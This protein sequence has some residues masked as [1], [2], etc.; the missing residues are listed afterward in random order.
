MCSNHFCNFPGYPEAFQVSQTFQAIRKLS[1][2]SGKYP[3]YPENIQPI[4]KTSSLS[5]KFPAYPETFQIIRKISSLSGKF[6]DNPEKIQTIWK[7][8]KGSGNFSV[9][10]YGLHAKTFR[11]RKNFPDD[12]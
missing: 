6:P 3:A 9:Q 5:R 8:S 2:S 4:W 10:F 7:F 12:L 11:T 1:R